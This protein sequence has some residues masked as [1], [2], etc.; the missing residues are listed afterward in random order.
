M[1]ISELKRMGANIKLKGSKIE[2]LGVKKLFGAEVM[3]T[4]L[5]A[6]SSLIIAGLMANGITTVNRVYHL[7]RG[8]ENLEEKLKKMWS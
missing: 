6:S 1:H 5:R 2:I 3:A 7:D 4:D 8:Y